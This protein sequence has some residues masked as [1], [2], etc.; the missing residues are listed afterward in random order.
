MGTKTDMWNKV[1]KKVKLNRY[2][3]PFTEIPYE[4]Y[5]QSPIGL[6]PKSG[7]QKTCLIFHLSYNFSENRKSLNY[8]TPKELCTAKYNDLDH[9]VANCLKLLEKVK[10]L[11]NNRIIVFAKT[12]VRSAFRLV[13]LRPD[14]YCWL[15]MKAE[16][17]I[18]GQIFYFIDKCLPFGAS[19][20]CA[21]FQ[22]FSDTLKHILC[23]KTGAHDNITNYLDDFLFLAYTKY[24]CDQLVTR[25]LLIYQE[26]GC[27][28]AEEKTEWG[29]ELIV[30]LGV[31]L[32]G[33][34]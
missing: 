5:M 12:D 32:D 18:S 20:S 24:L 31:L 30:F 10:M 15:I 13:P 6:V 19:I 11:H 17:L 27:P 4:N 16:H 34:N 9:A 25:F 3:R 1:M 8:H 28:I 26:V 21:I 22:S 2:S 33:R 29:T 14:Q 7:E 23:V